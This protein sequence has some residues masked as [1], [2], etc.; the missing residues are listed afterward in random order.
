MLQEEELSF[1]SPPDLSY[2]DTYGYFHSSD[3]VGRS[4]AWNQEQAIADYALANSA[5]EM[6]DPDASAYLLTR[7]ETWKNLYDPDIGFF[8]ARNSE[9]E[10][11]DLRSESAWGDEYAEG[12]AR[13][14]RWLVPHT[15]ENLFEV[16]GGKDTSLERLDEMF[17]EMVK[18]IEDGHQISVPENWYWHG[19]EPGLHIPYLFSLLGYPERTNYWVD[20]L[21]FHRYKNE[22][23]GLAGNDDGGTL[24]AWYIFSSLDFIHWQVRNVMS[25]VL[26]FLIVSSFKVILLP[27]SYNATRKTLV[28][29]YISIN[30]SGPKTISAILLFKMQVLYLNSLPICQYH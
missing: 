14:Y 28:T 9:G 7:S 30:K 4:V 20:W 8:H 15:P 18:E 24:S 2:L 3:L 13:Q 19:N 21:M 22:H 11:E 26:L 16:L 5:Y 1:G 6:E 17:Y 27:K 10:F 29:Q 12:N 25:L 23:D